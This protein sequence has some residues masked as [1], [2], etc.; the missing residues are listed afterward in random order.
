MTFPPN[1]FVIKAMKILYLCTHNR[2]RSILSE[3]ITNHLGQGKILAKS[4]GSE[5]AGEVHPLT[6]KYLSQAN[7][8]ID[9]LYSKAIEELADFNP[10][11]VITLCDSA[12]S[13]GCPIYFG[14]ALKLHW[15][16]A[17]PSKLADEQ[18]A[19]QAFKQSIDEISQRVEFLLGLSEQDKSTWTDALKQQGAI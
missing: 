15:G 18:Q 12:A 8:E 10:D 16:L 1:N 5:P 17:D 19:E 14:E 9:S 3:A 2:C 11:M 4:A 7:I 13:E 6:L